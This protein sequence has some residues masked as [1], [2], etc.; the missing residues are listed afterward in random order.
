MIHKTDHITKSQDS[1]IPDNLSSKL[2]KNTLIGGGAPCTKE[3]TS[4][5][6]TTEARYSSMDRHQK[7]GVELCLLLI[8]EH[9]NCLV[10]R[11][12]HRSI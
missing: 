4:G 8:G 12:P 5:S 11:D 7:D 10:N 9:I 6:E 2:N 1:H 3:G